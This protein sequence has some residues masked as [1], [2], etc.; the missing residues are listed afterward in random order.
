MIRQAEDEEAKKK[1][2]DLRI[3][4]LGDRET[5]TRERGSTPLEKYADGGRLTP[6]A[7]GTRCYSLGLT[8]EKPT[9]ICAPNANSKVRDGVIDP[10]TQMRADLAKV[11]VA[12]THEDPA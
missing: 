10:N 4:A 11:S 12:F 3:Q 9:T 1:L 2:D 7:P 8:Y 5:R 6:V